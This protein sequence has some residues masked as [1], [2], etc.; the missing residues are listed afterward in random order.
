LVAGLEAALAEAG[1]AL[2]TDRRDIQGQRIVEQAAW[3]LALPLAHAL[4]DGQPLP[5]GQPTLEAW[6]EDADAQ[7][8]PLIVAVNE[9]T[10][11][12]AQALRR[13]VRDRVVAAIVWIAQTTGRQDE[14]A[15]FA[16]EAEI[17]A[18]NGGVLHVREGCCLYYRVQGTVKCWSCPL[19]TDDE[20]RALA[21]L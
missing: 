9:A 17:R 5:G 14:A 21:G 11:R 7:L 15:R 16:P 20:R 2:G 12:P 8:E 10:G 18:F 6:R 13:G 3:E 1:R 19:L 4:L